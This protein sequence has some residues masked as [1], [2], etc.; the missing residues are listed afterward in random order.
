M[1]VGLL[2]GLGT[3]Y[4]YGLGSDFF[5]R[6]GSRSNSSLLN[7]RPIPKCSPSDVPLPRRTISQNPSSQNSDASGTPCW[8]LSLSMLC[9]STVLLDPRKP[10]PGILP[11][12]PVNEL[13]NSNGAHG[14]N[15]HMLLGN[16]DLRLQLRGA[17]G[18][19]EDQEVSARNYPMFASRSGRWKCRTSIDSAWESSRQPVPEDNQEQPLC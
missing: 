17:G 13:C 5:Q 2:V 6:L 12:T 14:P 7:T 8:N 10:F 4:G 9:V 19:V 3:C 16:V 1:L 15:L 11:L 18:L